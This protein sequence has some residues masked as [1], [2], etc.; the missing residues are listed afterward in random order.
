M[1]SIAGEGTHFVVERGML[2]IT[3]V[4]VCCLL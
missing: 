3:G 4:G 1:L 2:S